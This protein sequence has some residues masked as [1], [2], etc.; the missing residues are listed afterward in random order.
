M[1]VNKECNWTGL[2]TLEKI[3]NFY[4]FKIKLIR[5]VKCLEKLHIF[6]LNFNRNNKSSMV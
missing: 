1:K 4:S 2:K 5:K 6:F 3:I